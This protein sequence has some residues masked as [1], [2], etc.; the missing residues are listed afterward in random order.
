MFTNK[1][2]RMLLPW[3][4]RAALPTRIATLVVKDALRPGD[5]EDITAAR[6][7]QIRQYHRLLVVTVVNPG[8]QVVTDIDIDLGVSLIRRIFYESTRKLIV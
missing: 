1:E 2:R 4:Q 3:I 7:R 8:R 6:A 5:G